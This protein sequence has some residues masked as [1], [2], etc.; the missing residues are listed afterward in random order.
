[1]N[2]QQLQTCGNCD[3]LDTYMCQPW[4]ANYA[5][6]LNINNTTMEVLRCIDCIADARTVRLSKGEHSWKKEWRSW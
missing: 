2:D 6:R 5:K 4:C 1:M 3:G